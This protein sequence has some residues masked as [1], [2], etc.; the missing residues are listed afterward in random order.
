M[1][2]ER[3]DYVEPASRMHWRP[4][5]RVAGAF[6]LLI[7]AAVL[8]EWATLPHRYTQE[9]ADRIRPGMTPAQVED[10]FGRPPDAT[11]RDTAEWRGR[12]SFIDVVYRDGRVERVV[13]RS[14]E[15]PGVYTRWMRHLGLNP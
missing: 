5:R 14:D 11:G 7:V 1:D 8:V 3:A 2:Q 4:I 9:E 6:L 15:P 10:I 13:C 12:A